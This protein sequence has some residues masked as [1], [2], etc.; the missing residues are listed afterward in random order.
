[1]CNHILLTH[2]KI[3]LQCFAF[4]LTEKRPEANLVNVVSYTSHE[5]KNLEDETLSAN[6]FKNTEHKSIHYICIYSVFISV[7]AVLLGLKLLVLY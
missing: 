3:C 1:M 4:G 6:S 2:P 5:Q 7:Q